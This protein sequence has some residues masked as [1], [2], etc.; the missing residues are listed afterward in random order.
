LERNYKT[1]LEE[2]GQ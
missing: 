2:P 1:S